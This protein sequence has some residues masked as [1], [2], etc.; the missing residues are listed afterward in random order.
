M[1]TNTKQELTRLIDGLTYPSESD[2]PFEVVELPAGCDPSHP[3]KVCQA[4][5]LDAAGPI[6]TTTVEK[7][8][9]GA[10]GGEQDAQYDALAAALSKAF[11]DLTVLR[12]GKI[13][14]S[15]LVLGRDASGAWGGVRTLSVET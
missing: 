3:D 15:V 7:F 8:I 13:N 11:Q 5:K 4:L 1:D 2:E 9:A 14:V 12:I 6:K 10:K